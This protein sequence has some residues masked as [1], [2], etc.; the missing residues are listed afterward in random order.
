M[1]FGLQFWISSIGPSSRDCNSTGAGVAVHGNLVS[2]KLAKERPADEP[3][4]RED[5]NV[6]LATKTILHSGPIEAHRSFMRAVDL[7]WTADSAK[8][9]GFRKKVLTFRHAQGAQL[10]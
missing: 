10:C 5:L 8:N 3:R 1:R 9:F 4:R 6:L 2:S 7:F